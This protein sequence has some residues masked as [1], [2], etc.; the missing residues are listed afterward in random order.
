MS[1]FDYQHS[2][3]MIAVFTFVIAVLFILFG[4]RLMKSSPDTLQAEEKGAA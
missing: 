1:T 4:S 3:D 2:Y